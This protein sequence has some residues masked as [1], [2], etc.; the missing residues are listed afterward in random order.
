[1]DWTKRVAALEQLPALVA[2][3]WSARTAGA[4]SG[5]ARPLLPWRAP[6]PVA[7]VVSSPG[8]A[9]T[10]RSL[11]Q[12]ARPL[13]L[14]SPQAGMLDEVL[15][16]LRAPLAAQ[17][18]DLRSQPVRAYAD[19]ALEPPQADDRWRCSH[20]CGP[21]YSWNRACGALVALAQRLGGAL[22][23]LV[24]GVLPQ[25]MKNLC[26]ACVLISTASTA[27]A[28]TAAATAAT[29]TFSATCCRL[30]LAGSSRSRRSRSS[31]SRR[32]SR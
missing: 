2:D 6:F 1:M 14:V 31:R 20:A 4:V 16:P 12:T 9:R 19:A 21:P 18:G 17:L 32:C 11:L 13:S 30:H 29:P 8:S 22:A 26:A 3:A 28:A 25:L 10:L 23:P 27:T 5:P 15:P 7:P 24:P